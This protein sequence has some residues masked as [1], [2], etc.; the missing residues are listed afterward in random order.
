MRILIPV[1]YRLGIALALFAVTMFVPLVIA[2]LGDD[3]EP[4]A[5]GDAFAITFACGAFLYVVTRA[6]VGRAARELQPREAF[7]LASLLWTVP[8]FFAALPFVFHGLGGG[9]IGAYFEAVS[10]LTTT[11]ATVLSGLDALPPSLLVWRALLVWIGGMGFLVL[12]VA[13]LPWLGVGGYQ[14]FKAAT[15][16]PMKDARLTPRIA[17]TAKGL[18]GVYLALSLACFLALR[19]AGMSWL[20]AFC[21]MC[22]ILGLGGFSTHDANFA[23]FDSLTIEIVASFFMVVAALNFA[24]HFRA[25]QDKRL[26]AHLRS[27]ESRWTVAVIALAVA[28][29]TV[30]LTAHHTYPDWTSALRAAL[31]NTVSLATTAG[32]SSAD[33]NAWPAFAPLL[34]L[35]LS[36]FAASAGTAGGGVKMIRALLLTKQ[37]GRELTRILHPRVVNPVL[38]AGVHVENKVIFSV[39]AF[40]L[41]YGIIFI[42]LTLLMLASGLDLVT[43][44]SAV[45]ACLNNLG[46]GLNRVGP[47]ATYATLSD[48]Q[49]WVCIAAMLLGRLE[50]FTLLVVFTPG[51]WR[52]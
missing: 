27:P 51:F 41:A 42:G 14:V 11:G 5:Y 50:L 47:T 30:A 52:K 32:F 49:A 22:S 8:P 1:L 6:I 38:L 36:C 26:G 3:T 48:F 7:L 35:L 44:F 9:F 18:Y 46:P 33:Y 23:Y 43:A 25:W 29:V 15:P 31:F 28:A 4:S 21:H 19:W 2:W 16:G 39:L 20:D 40:M 13:I 24:T 10:G 37:A 17:E 12:A 34:M 45:L